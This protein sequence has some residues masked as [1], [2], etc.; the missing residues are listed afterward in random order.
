[1]KQVIVTK[2][3]FEIII[4]DIYTENYRVPVALENLRDWS[5]VQTL[6][7]SKSLVIRS[8]VSR[9]CSFHTNTVIYLT[10]KKLEQCNI[11]NNTI[12][13]K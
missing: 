1:M 13:I 6:R 9:N 2:L 10:Y 4:P 12:K 3:C 7:G 8:F 5:K 11:N